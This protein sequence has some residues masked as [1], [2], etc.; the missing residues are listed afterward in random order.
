EG[1]Q[2]HQFARLNALALMLV[3]I[4]IVEAFSTGLRAYCYGLGAERAALRLRRLVFDRLLR[5]DVQF[6]DRRDTGEIT[7]RLSA[8]VPALQFVL[9]EE[10]ADAVR[11]SVIAVAGTAL[12]FYT[13][14]RLSLITLLAVPPIVLATSFLGKKVRTLAGDMQQA[15]A[16][17]GAAATEV[18]AGIRTVRAFGQEAA[19]LRRYDAQSA[20][21]LDVA[22]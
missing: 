5:Q 12:L 15:H 14:I 22:R 1:V 8:D 6:F 7:T 11:F 19:E 16:D 2:G 3:A 17:T 10:L 4:L 13:S 18:I 9:G 21:T 20:R